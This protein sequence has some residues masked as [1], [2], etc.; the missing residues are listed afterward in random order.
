MPA[1]AA[2]IAATG[3][4]TNAAIAVTTVPIMLAKLPIHP[5]T[6]VTTPIIEPIPDTKGP[7]IKSSGPRAPTIA[8]ITP[9]VF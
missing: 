2:T 3:A 5:T 9:I 8:I 4:P 1:I 6:V 7:I